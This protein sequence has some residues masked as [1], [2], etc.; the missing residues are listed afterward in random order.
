MTLALTSNVKNYL[1]DLVER[2]QPDV[3]ILDIR[4]PRLSGIEVLRV[5]R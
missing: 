4:M 2:L 5:L 1:L 3:A